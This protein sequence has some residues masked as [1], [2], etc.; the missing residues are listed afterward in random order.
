MT[1]LPK[2]WIR[3]IE[4]GLTETNQIPLWGSPP[5]FDFEGCAQA[6]QE[7][8]GLDSLKITPLAA[9]WKGP[10]QGLVGFGDDPI[11]TPIDIPTLEGRAL[12]VMAKDDANWFTKASLTHGED[13]KRSFSSPALVAGFYR[14]ALL[15]VLATFRYAEAFGDL[16]P[17]IGPDDALPDSECMCLDIQIEVNGHPLMGRLLCPTVFF[18]SFKQHFSQRSPDLSS[19]SFSSI[20]L[21]LGLVVGSTQLN[22]NQWKG[23][24]VGDFV[25]LDR[26]LYDVEAKKGS[27]EV[28]LGKTPIFHA[29]L[30]EGTLKILDYSF[31]YE[32]DNAMDERDPE[33]ELD[34]GLPEDE[35]MLDDFPE[36]EPMPGDED[37]AQEHLW[38]ADK[39]EAPLDQML[40]A[41]E[42][43]IELT[44]EVGRL[45]M[46]LERLLEL[47]PGN[48]LELKAKPEDVVHLSANGKRV[49]T[50][51]LVKIGD[52][53]GI[54][55]LKLG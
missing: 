34:E 20:P 16:S 39:S 1:A 49:G 4:D 24:G 18:H 25:V 10:G 51:E 55:I 45:E 9:A 46:S 29:R 48:T 3:T 6:L 50:A 30:K 35:G 54:K 7:S 14:Y 13:D 19:K 23:V 8:F 36:D 31:Y 11:L 42:V 33:D 2:E 40:A 37:D 27:L 21:D 47:K 41:S 28:T 44:V 12:W 22:F 43:P 5:P 17:V 38:E 26:C 52:L 53:L 15:D 32:E